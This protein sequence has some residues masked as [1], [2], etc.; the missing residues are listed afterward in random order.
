MGIRII[1]TGEFFTKADYLTRLNIT[2]F[3]HI[4]TD[5]IPGEL[6]H[7]NML[8][9]DVKRSLLLLLKNKSCLCP[10]TLYLK[11]TKNI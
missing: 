2:F 8:S 1:K 7:E 10:I 4:N 6:S 5:E 3:Y 9:S 11:T